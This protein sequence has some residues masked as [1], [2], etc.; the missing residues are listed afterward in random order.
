MAK[1]DQHRVSDDVDQDRGSEKTVRVMRLGYRKQRFRGGI[2]LTP[3][4]LLPEKAG[5]GRSSKI[6]LLAYGADSFIEEDC[7]RLER[8]DELRREHPVVW[9]RVLG[10]EDAERIREL[11]SHVGIHPLAVEDVLNSHARSKVELYENDLLV[12]TKAAVRDRLGDA[13]LVDH[14]VFFMGKGLCIS[15]QESEEELFEPVVNRIRQGS[16]KIRMRKVDYLL[17]ALM[18]VIVDHLL[19]VL[20]DVETDIMEMEERM[21]DRGEKCSLGEIYQRKRFVLALARIV[22][23]SRENANRLETL[24]LQLI[25]KGNRYYFRDLADNARRAWERVE[26]ARLVLQNLQEYFH[27]QQEHRTNEQMKVLTVFATLFMP[28][29][30]ITGVYGMNFSNEAGHLNMP[31]LHWPYGYVVVLGIMATFFFGMLGWFKYRKWI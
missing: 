25:E 11:C 7:D 18:D 12:V 31:E 5:R 19:S 16:G 21:L 17:F 10:L 13:I 8:L 1:K 24:D 14:V 22:L 28:L 30:F 3:G 9:L 2:G 26:H 15:F 27:L 20:D 23:P 6:K 4:E 29:T